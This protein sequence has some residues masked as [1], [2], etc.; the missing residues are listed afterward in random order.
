MTAVLYLLAFLSGAAALIYQVTWTNLLALSFGTLAW[1]QRRLRRAL[2]SPR[3]ELDEGA[4]I[5]VHLAQHEARS[6]NRSHI[7]QTEASASSRAP[8]HEHI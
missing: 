4:E 7:W 8:V 1:W 2:G 6:R 5:A 3:V